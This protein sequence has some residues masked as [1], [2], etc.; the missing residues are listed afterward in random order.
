[1]AN[2]IYHMR[3]E[4][5]LVMDDLHNLRQTYAR[6]RTNKTL[7]FMHA[8]FQQVAEKSNLGP[9]AHAN[10]PSGAEECA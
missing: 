3:A 6:R 9:V 4:Y 8:G 10:R 7:T 1:M 2:W 5:I